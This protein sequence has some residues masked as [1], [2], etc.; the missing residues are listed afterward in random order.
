MKLNSALLVAMALA[1]IGAVTLPEQQ[2]Q[3]AP[4]E[5]R[6]RGI[7]L[8]QRDH[9]T[10]DTSST[11]D[12]GKHEVVLLTAYSSYFFDEDTNGPVHTY[13]SGQNGFIIYNADSSSGAPHYQGPIYV[14]TYDTNSQQ[15]TYS[16]TNSPPSFSQTVANLLNDGY[17][18]V[19]SSFNDQYG[20]SPTVLLVK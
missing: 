3:R 13:I 12:T 16:V 11:G 9:K 4:L 17:K 10:K 8:P 15:S 18:I 20:P 14:S 1:A 19:N 6:P 2:Q 7:Q 5:E